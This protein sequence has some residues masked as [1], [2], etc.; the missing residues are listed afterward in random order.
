MEVTEP[1]AERSKQPSNNR[2][3][4]MSGSTKLGT[5]LSAHRDSLQTFHKNMSDI[6]MQSPQRPLSPT[7]FS[8]RLSVI[9]TPDPNLNKPLPKIRVTVDRTFSW[10]DLSS[11][12]S[13]SR[14]TI[15]VGLAEPFSR[16]G[17]TA[18]QGRGMLSRSTDVPPLPSPVSA[19]QPATLRP[20]SPITEEAQDARQTRE[21]SPPG[22]I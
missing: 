15:L 18:T 14:G 4:F 1:L 17:S 12:A 2:S 16:P 9:R 3:S 22:S 6:S 5:A 11:R 21:S 8:P 20:V 10:S 7:Q 19:Y 13:D